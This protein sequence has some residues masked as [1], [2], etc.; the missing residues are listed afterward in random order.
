MIGRVAA[1]L[2]WIACYYYDLW[3]IIPKDDHNILAI[4]L[5]ILFCAD[6][7]SIISYKKIVK[8]VRKSEE[9]EEE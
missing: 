5:L 9:K 8:E 3:N 7:G 2:I 4:G 1:L 6:D